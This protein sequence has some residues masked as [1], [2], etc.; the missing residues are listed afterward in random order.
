VRRSGVSIRPVFSATS[1]NLLSFGSK[2][3][4]ANVTSWGI[5]N[6]DSVIVGRLLGIVDLG[7]YGRVMTLVASPTGAVVSGVQGVL[8]AACSRAQA[9]PE[10]LKRAFL[11]A[12][13]GVVGLCLPVFVTVASVPDAVIG[14]VYGSRWL[15][16]TP[17]LV[18]LALAMPLYA[19][20][21]LVGPVLTATNRVTTE[22]RAQ[23]LTLVLMFAVL[24]VAGRHSL[25][26]VAWGMLFVYA[27]RCFL[28]VHPLLQVIGAE[29]L[30]LLRPLVWP[31]MCAAVT[32][33]V[34]WSGDRSL[35]DTAALP[36]LA[37]DVGLAT[38]ALLV[39]GRI[40]GKQLLDGPH[41]EFLLAEGRLPSNV[42]D[43]LITM[44]GTP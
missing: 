43:W 29:W 16:A 33:M 41:G 26:A 35:R 21:A 42:R 15:A 17:L 4:A 31:A 5:A 10:K 7:L 14:G 13:T 19:L 9:A 20:L 36:R 6:A 28:L 27:V 38:A 18:P 44:R 32:A 23:V 3:I 30:E 2:V 25:Q 37:F 22:L 24:L 39:T 11:G 40:F 1:G 8:F 34:T 12:A